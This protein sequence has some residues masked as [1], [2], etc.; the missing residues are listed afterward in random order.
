MT[1]GETVQ[2]TDTLV[3]GAGQSGLATSHFL[4]KAGVEHLVV[5]R[6]DRLGGSWHDRWDEFC[7]VLP[8]F[9]LLLPGMPYDGDDP[10][11]A[12]WYADWRLPSYSGWGTRDS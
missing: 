1:N 9:T 2:R 10:D 11:G 3:I 6:R 12:W 4:T 5:D 8:N 7:L